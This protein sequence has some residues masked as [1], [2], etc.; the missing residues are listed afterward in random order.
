MKIGIIGAGFT[1]LAAAHA[2]SKAGHQVTVFEKDFNPGG[3]ALGFTSSNWDWSLEK[4]YHHLFTGD[5][6]ILDLAAEINFPI[7]FYQPITSTVTTSGVYQLDSPWHLL[8]F[9]DISIVDRV[10]VGMVLAYLRLTPLWQPLEKITSENFLSLTMGKKAWE[11]LWKPLFV[12][13]FGSRYSEISAAWFWARIKKRSR[14]LGY[15]RGGFFK[16]AQSI[17]LACKK[18][19]V[20]FLFS[21][22]IQKVIQNRGGLKLIADNDQTYIFDRVICT[23]PNFMF[24]RIAPELPKAYVDK[25]TS[26]EGIG[27]VNLV[28]SLKHKFLPGGIY[29][30]NI[31]KPKLPFLAVVEHTNFISPSHYGGESL[32]YIGNYLPLDHRYFSLSDKELLSEFIPALKSLNTHFSL[33][34]VVKSWIGK[35]P[36]AQ[37]IVTLNYSHRIPSH[38]TP[39]PGLFLANIQQVYPWDRGTNYAVEMGLKVARLCL[40][41]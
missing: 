11:V 36:F 4:H 33:D 22:G 9:P 31:N 38:I 15:P 32:I 5:K 2:L 35:A 34:W 23:L 18:N 26:L 39:I 13:K 27:A 1:G 30:L 24:A 29:W 40:K 7:D 17:T 20:H 6:A 8:N 10:R 16:L 14:S 3:L 12:G 25:I 41:K 21:T 19:G 37:P 28:L